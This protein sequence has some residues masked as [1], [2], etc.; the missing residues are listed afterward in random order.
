MNPSVLRLLW[1]VIE[2]TEPKLLLRLKNE[3]LADFVLHEMQEQQFLLREERMAMRHYIQAKTAMIHD[4]AQSKLDERP[5]RMFQ[6][7]RKPSD[8]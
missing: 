5:Q 2:E 6:K 4:I 3:L 7:P 1:A 8:L